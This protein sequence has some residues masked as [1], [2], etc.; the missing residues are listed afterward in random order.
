M[1]SVTEAVDERKVRYFSAV[2]LATALRHRELLAV[3]AAQKFIEQAALPNARL[4]GDGDELTFAGD[5]AVDACT[6]GRELAHAIDMAGEA[7]LLRRLEARANPRLGDDA[8]RHERRR[9]AFDGGRRQRLQLEVRHRQPIRAGT[10]QHLVGAGERTEAR[11]GVDRVAGQLIEAFAIVPVLREDE[12]GV[13]AGVD[14]EPLA[15]ARLVFAHRVANRAVQFQRRAHRA[16]R[17]VL[18][19]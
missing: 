4:P 14:R 13:D 19:G 3:E 6:E 16:H 9:L 2:R 12:P 17:V 10:D 1:Q 11:R 15:D 7:A 18:F 5:G 8:M